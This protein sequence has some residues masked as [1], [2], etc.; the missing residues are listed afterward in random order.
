MIKPRLRLY[1]CAAAVVVT[2]GGTVLTQ[3]AGPGE[4]ISRLWNREP[5]PKK[6][7]TSGFSPFRWLRGKKSDSTATR[8]KVSDGGRTV[9]SERP[10]LISDPFLAAQ[11]SPAAQQSHG[12]RP[13][14]S[15]SRK[16]IV[17]PQPRSRT[18]AA[19]NPEANHD[20]T[21][22]S[23]PAARRHLPELTPND[24]N[25][26]DTVASTQP[27][28]AAR[29]ADNGGFVDGFDSE[30]QK[31]VA[32]VVSESRQKKKEDIATPRLPDDLGT[33][34]SSPQ[35]NASLETTIAD[36]PADGQQ[37]ADSPLEQSRETVSDLIRESRRQ[38]ESS[39]LA[40][41]A[42]GK[43]PSERT[44]SNTSLTD[45]SV[46]ERNDVAAASH[47]HS[48]QTASRSS[49]PSDSSFLPQRLPDQLGHN[50]NQLVVPSH[51]VPDRELFN[52]TDAWMNRS[53]N[54]SY[55]AGAEADSQQTQPVT[56]VIPGSR[57]N[58][59]MIESG[60]WSLVRPRVS[61]NVAP[62]RSVPDTSKFRRLSFDGA[63]GPSQNG[64][65]L[66]VGEVG[67]NGRN[68]ETESGQ[69]GSSSFAPP[70][71]AVPSE[72]PSEQEAENALPIMLPPDGRADPAN[73]AA[74]LGAT[75]SAAP[76]PPQ[77]QPAVFDWPDES[78]FAPV[79]PTGG[80][81]W[82]TAAFFLVLTG[83]VASLFFRRKRQNGTFG[84]TGTISEPENS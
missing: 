26:L 1:V 34:V 10:E 6:E 17:R 43:G 30:F 53:R 5:A 80:V 29:P 78:E 9:V 46:D 54:Q 56:Q 51:I 71:L 13:V 23:A 65:V 25:G 82:G 24:D 21:V 67:K 12:S 64:A 45:R 70:A 44:R 15:T 63:A 66:A 31:L 62:S 33:D 83:G 81:S 28:H 3:A 49:A 42:A 38:M 47:S 72:L 69:T 84:I 8:V 57:G 35:Q 48:N 7:V 36:S 18:E 52:P 75:L 4:F 61:S 76:G 2:L 58:G 27:S 39:T 73:D 50:G 16:I 32:S 77:L 19:R 79:S 37:F 41:R 59:V 22:A 74:E 11:Q 68:E 60:Q 20:S 14:V 55:E 40:Q